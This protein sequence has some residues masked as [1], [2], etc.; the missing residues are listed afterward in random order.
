MGRVA[1][2]LIDVVLTGSMV[3]H[4]VV[5]NVAK[6]ILPKVTEFTENSHVNLKQLLLY[7]KK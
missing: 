2:T 3:F 7:K 6:M 4:Y 1:S 5:Y